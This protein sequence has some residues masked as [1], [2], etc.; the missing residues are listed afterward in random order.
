MTPTPQPVTVALV[1]AGNRGQTYAR[2]IAEHPERARLVA[3]ADPRAHQRG[4]V[5]DQAV[6]A[7]AAAAQAGGPAD[8][9]VTPAA[10]T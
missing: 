4:L 6:A 7:Q 1:G 10:T 9:A 8:P 5:V 3:V 2:W